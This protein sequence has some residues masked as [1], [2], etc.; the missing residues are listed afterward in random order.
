ML[1][2]KSKTQGIQNVRAASWRAWKG[3]VWLSERTLTIN[4]QDLERAGK[5]EFT[6]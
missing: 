3:D 1:W 4:M 5:H 6:L 2:D